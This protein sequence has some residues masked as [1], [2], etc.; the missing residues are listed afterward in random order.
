MVRGGFVKGGRPRRAP[1]T[2]RTKKNGNPMRMRSRRLIGFIILGGHQAWCPMPGRAHKIALF[3]TPSRKKALAGRVQIVPV[4]D[5]QHSVGG[6]GS[7]PAADGLFRPRLPLHGEAAGPR[8]SLR[9]DRTRQPASSLFPASPGFPVSALDT[10]R[11]RSAAP[12]RGPRE[13]QL[14][15]FMRRPEVRR[16]MT[17]RVGEG[18]G[19][20]G[21]APPRPR[22]FAGHTVAAEPPPPPSAAAWQPSLTLGPP[23]PPSFISFIIQWIFSF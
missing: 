3:W 14:L 23:P 22:P 2:I 7:R 19:G 13:A 1:N 4:G 15:L 8:A 12:W 10:L 11:G 5:L 17:C 21:P 20:S 16:G 18:Q 6:G 9:P